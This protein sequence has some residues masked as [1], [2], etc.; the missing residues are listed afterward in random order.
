M[1]LLENVPLSTYSTM[2][3]GGNARYLTEVANRNELGATVAWAKEQNLPVL[4]VG[5]GSNIVWTDA[6]FPGVVLVNRMMG[7]EVQELTETE[8][9]ITAGAGMNWDEFVAKTVEQGL[10]GVELLSLVPGT[11]GAT[12]VQNVGAY[13]QEVSSSIVTIQAY[14][15]QTNQFVTLRGSDCGFGYR[16]SIFKTTERGRYFIISV[17]FFLR[18]GNPEPPYYAS[19]AQYCQQHGISR[20]TPTQGRQATIQ[21]RTSKLPDP[22]KVANNGSFF[23]NPIITSEQ[24]VDLQADFPDVSY[25]PIG[26]SGTVKL[27]AAWLIEQAGFKDF[28]DPETGMA[29]WPTQPLVL[30][31]ESAQSTA[32]LL[33]F[34]QKIVDAVATKFS[35]MLTQ[36]PELLGS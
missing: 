11:V 29:T 22:A 5:T 1:F 25:W 24:F 13:G 21:I 20:L 28:H 30:V 26:D 4:M 9:Y 6:G 31:N 32:Q 8:V 14:D 33:A 23:A 36:E 10:T 2:R 18:K 19:I 7:Y 3:L 27:S 35:V 16:T 12:P 15:S 17:T 34:K